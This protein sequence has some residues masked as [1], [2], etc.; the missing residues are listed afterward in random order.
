MKARDRSDELLAKAQEI[1]R[2]TDAIEARRA[3]KAAQDRAVKDA[4]EAGRLAAA[5]VALG[6]DRMRDIN[7]INRD[8]WSEHQRRMGER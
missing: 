8:F 5:K 6:I 3:V 7:K 4:E 1:K 2:T